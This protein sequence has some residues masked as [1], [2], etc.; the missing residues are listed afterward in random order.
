V[1]VTIH[2]WTTG[3]LTVPYVEYTAGHATSPAARAAAS[4]FGLEHLEPLGMLPGRLASEAARMGIVACEAEV[5][6]EGITLPERRTL[7]A[8]GVVGVMRHMGMV[9]G[10]AP[11]PEG[12]RD[13]ARHQVVAEVGGAFRRSDQARVG[14]AVA[15]GEPI[16][17]ICD[18]NGRPLTHVRAPADGILAVLRHALSIE[19][20]D[21]AAV[22]FAPAAPDTPPVSG[23]L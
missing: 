1:L 11:L 15:A 10:E 21:L 2:G 4:A 20:G 14:V 7:A 6:G 8:R 12:Q 13:V 22:I 23:L 19:P 9:A 3:W 5:G 17:A 18:L 16:G